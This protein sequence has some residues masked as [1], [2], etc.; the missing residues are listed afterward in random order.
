LNQNFNQILFYKKPSFQRNLIGLFLIIGG[1][2]LLY[3]PTIQYYKLS[4]TL[5]LFGIF[6]ILLFN[7][8]EMEENTSQIKKIKGEHLTIILLIWTSIIFFI[9]LNVDFD[10][11]LIVNVLG[12]A[13]IREFITKN[14]NTQLKNRLSFIV[15]M[16]FII[17]I[18]IAIKKVI[19]I[20]NI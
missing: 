17:F 11:Y 19:Y 8:K 9:T 14:I 15:Y 13:T 6:I 3:N 20:I 12:I 1:I 18:I 5:I 7:I 16:C 4:I 2:T 10:I